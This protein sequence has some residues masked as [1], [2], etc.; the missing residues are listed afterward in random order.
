MFSTLYI[1]STNFTRESFLGRADNV[2]RVLE[3][4]KKLAMLAKKQ[5]K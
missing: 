5:K 3:H 2:L 1:A 4:D